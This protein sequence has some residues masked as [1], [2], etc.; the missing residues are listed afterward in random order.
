MEASVLQLAIIALMFGMF[1]RN[2]PVCIVGWATQFPVFVGL[3]V[4]IILG[5]PMTGM[6][7]GAAINL[8]YIS[9]LD[10]G[11][12]V[13]ANPHAAVTIGATMAIVANLDSGAA[14][15]LAVPF[16]AVATFLTPLIQTINIPFASRVAAN[17]RKANFK[18]L[19]FWHILAWVVSWLIGAVL[20][21]I[22]LYLGASVVGA[23]F[24]SLPPYILRG[25]NEVAKVMP[26]LGIAMGLTMVANKKGYI[27]FFILSFILAKV[28]GL[29]TLTL[30]IIAALLVWVVLSFQK[31][32]VAHDDIVETVQPAEPEK[33]H[34][35]DFKTVMKSVWIWYLAFYSSI[36]YEKMS[37]TGVLASMVPVMKKLYPND[38]E[39][40]GAE[41]AKYDCYFQTN[42]QFNAVILGMEAAMEE[43]RASG[44]DITPEAIISVQTGLMGP[45]AGIGDPIFQTIWKPL[46]ASI[47]IT[48]A[49]QGN[50]AGALLPFFGTIIFMLVVMYVFARLS[51][52]GGHKIVGKLFSSGII[53]RVTSAASVVG[54]VA[55]GALAAS[56]VKVGCGIEIPYG[57]GMTLNF[58]TNVFDSILPGLLPLALSLLC[59]WL[60]AKKN[61]KINWLLLI[62]L[63]GSILLGAL[64]ILA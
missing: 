38:P 39:K 33:K 2:G 30:V 41:I 22:T 43:E 28:L 14:I 21:F 47:G 61:V 10:V 1:Q 60:L 54:C 9:N 58:Q 44:K 15:A 7:I 17:A 29:S 32:K 56:T 34:L 18:G 35:L 40:Q 23:V 24:E 13:S 55:F 52:N 26:A 6:L 3:L 36:G 20:M 42:P 62:M 19:Y 53:D 64:G 45:L 27:A 16:G 8:I 57:E 12:V 46:I 5:D 59:Y 63:L 31:V 48:L 25:L 49:M 51:Y 37:G 50:Y 4:G 11:T